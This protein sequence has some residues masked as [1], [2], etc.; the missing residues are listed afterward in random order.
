MTMFKDAKILDAEG[1]LDVE[2]LENYITDHLRGIIDER[3]A[4]VENRIT[5]TNGKLD[6]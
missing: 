1:M 2:L 6:S 3:Y 4:Q 5:F